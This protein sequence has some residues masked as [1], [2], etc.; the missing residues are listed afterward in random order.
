MHKELAVILHENEEGQVSVQLH[1]GLK[2][3]RESFRNLHGRVQDPPSRV[4]FVAIDFERNK[5]VV[6]TKTLP[7]KDAPRD[8]QPDGIVLGKG[9]IWLDKE[10]EDE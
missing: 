2:K 8:D 4:T 9:P 1:A 10:N 3:A 7:V 6:R 5:S